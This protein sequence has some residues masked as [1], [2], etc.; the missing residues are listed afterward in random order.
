MTTDITTVRTGCYRHY[1]GNLYEVIATARHS[2]T[3]ELMVV[4]RCLYGDYSLWVRP[5]GMFIG[6]VD[7]DGQKLPR[8]EFCH[9]GV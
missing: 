7:V 6:Q 8:F 2:E 9:K 3:E 1:K 4:Y 5:L